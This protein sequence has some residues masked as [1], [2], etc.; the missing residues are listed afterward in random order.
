MNPF[1]SKL[2]WGPSNFDVKSNLHVSVLYYFPKVGSSGFMGHMLNGWWTGNIITTQTGQPFSPLIGTDREQAGLNG[3]K[4]GLERPSVVTAANLATLQAAAVAAGVTTCPAG[5]SNCVPYNP[6]VYNPK[7]V[8]THGVNQWFN[9][10]M[11]AL[12]PVG[13]IGNLGRNTLREPGLT[14]WD[15]SLNKDTAWARLGEAGVVQ[16]RAE[17]FN[18]LNH[19][20]LGPANNSIFNGS[21]PD[22]VETSTPTNITSQSN[23]S[24][25]IQFSLKAIF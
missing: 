13:T 2:E 4:G 11:F 17:M 18:V 16:F 19:P 5:S 12:Q 15:I 3:S 8:I 24:R 7:T 22:S 20:A 23:S 10:N 1:D 14:Q 25:Q 21:L 6:V 9:S